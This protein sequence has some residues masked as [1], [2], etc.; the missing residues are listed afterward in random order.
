MLPK[1]LASEM[2]RKV[3]VGTPDVAGVV[4]GASTQVT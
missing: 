1:F 3:E 4:S 2:V